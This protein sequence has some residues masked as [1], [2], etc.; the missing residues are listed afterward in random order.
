MIV[1]K[2]ETCFDNIKEKKNSNLSSKI[3]KLYSKVNQH[4]SRIDS[5]LNKVD[6][7]SIDNTNLQTIVNQL[8]V[9]TCTINNPIDH[10]T[11]TQKPT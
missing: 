11:C 4:I 3:D 9:D 10:R 2:L 5:V 1:K 7:L 6:K 8:L